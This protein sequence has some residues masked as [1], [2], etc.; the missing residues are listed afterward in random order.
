MTK[1]QQSNL[2][3]TMF[4]M[5]AEGFDIP[6]DEEQTL[7]DILEGRSTYKDV[8]ARYVEEAHTHAGV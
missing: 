8:L 7:I 3:E 1:K 6:P 5:H 2:A 4:T